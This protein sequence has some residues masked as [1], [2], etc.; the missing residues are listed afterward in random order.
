MDS[1]REALVQL[2][3]TL[4]TTTFLLIS[5][6]LLVGGLALALARWKLQPRL[7]SIACA[8]WWAALCL[9]LP[10]QGYNYQIYRHNAELTLAGTDAFERTDP[11]GV[12]PWQRA[13][14]LDYTGA[15]HLVYVGLM[16]AEQV[17]PNLLLEGVGFRLWNLL[18]GLG[19]M[20]LLWSYGQGAL[21]P[22]VVLAF[23]P[24]IALHLLIYAWE[25]KLLF[26]AIPL[27]AALL[28]QRE[29]WRALAFFSGLVTVYN[30][31]LLLWLPSLAIVLW[32]RLGRRALVQAGFLL[33]A[34]LVL[35]LLPFFPESLGG[36]A[37]RALRQSAETPFW[38]A[39]YGL[40]P[41]GWYHP[42][43]DKALIG[44]GALIGTWLLWRGR[45]TPIDTLVLTVGLTT[46]LGPYNGIARVVPVLIAIT[47]LTPAVRWL[48]WARLAAALLLYF[49][50][51]L[52]FTPAV[53]EPVHM[54]IFYLP[55][56]W[57]LGVYVRRRKA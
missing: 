6:L 44:G 1:V 47:A 32:R 42:L 10:L 4:A 55:V 49:T 2:F 16:A 52:G 56:A 40:L 21:A 17:A 19:L 29:Q 12:Q 50:V 54:V 31:L 11:P 20:G 46:L 30:G 8:L 36:W 24:A 28:L 35:G 27:A 37:N 53:I 25:D 33:S 23:H 15:Q 22:L 43:L 13:Q 39:V 45:L 18:I 51:S 26:A 38:F 48:D 7:L 9:S 34:G 41:N 5:L 3:R 57:V 14:V